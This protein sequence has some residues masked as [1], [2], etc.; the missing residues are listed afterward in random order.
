MSPQPPDAPPGA[1][2][3]E[4]RPGRSRHAAT[5][6]GRPGPADRDPHP[7]ATGPSAPPAGAEQVEVAVP[8]ARAGTG[9]R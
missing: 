7:P 3:P 9:R 5:R 1:T 8:A 6:R 4:A 2:A